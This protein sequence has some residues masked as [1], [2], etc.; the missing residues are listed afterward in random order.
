MAEAFEKVDLPSGAWVAFR[1]P[2]SLTRG[3]RKPLERARQRI[4]LARNLIEVLEGGKSAGDL[5]DNEVG[6]LEGVMEATAFVLIQ[7]WSFEQPILI[8]SFDELMPDDYEALMDA[9]KKHRPVLIPD[10]QPTIDQTDEEGREN[11]TGPSPASKTSS[12][13]SKSTVTSPT[14]SSEPSGS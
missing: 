14:T 2:K 9:G 12:A 7:E 5:E 8:T 10:F 1:D 4:G 13:G 6:L 3:Q 11:P